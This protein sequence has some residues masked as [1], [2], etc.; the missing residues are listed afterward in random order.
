MLGLSLVAVR[1]LLMQWLLLVWSMRSRELGFQ[2][3]QLLGFRAQ[4]Q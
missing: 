1:R 4:T 3:L 2:S